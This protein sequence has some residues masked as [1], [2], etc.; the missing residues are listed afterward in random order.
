VAE[1]VLLMKTTQAVLSL[2][3]WQTMLYELIILLKKD[4]P[5]PHVQPVNWTSAFDL[6]IPPPTKL[7][8][9]NVCSI[10]I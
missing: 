4:K 5:V 3:K 9:H 8:P 1:Q 2:C 6:H 7:M 10:F